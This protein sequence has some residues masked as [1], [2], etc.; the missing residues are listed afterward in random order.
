[1]TMHELR[2]NSDFVLRTFAAQRESAN[3]F[4]YHCG[5]C[6]FQYVANTSS[7][8]VILEGRLALHLVLDHVDLTDLVMVL[9]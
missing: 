7:S 8:R 2:V 3:W 9:R 6:D 5:L 1:M 4:I